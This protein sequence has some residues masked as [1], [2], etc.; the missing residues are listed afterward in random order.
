[1]KGCIWDTPATVVGSN[2]MIIFAQQEIL[3]DVQPVCKPM[4]CVFEVIS[5]NSFF[6]LSS[7]KISSCHM[8]QVWFS[9]VLKGSLCLLKCSWTIC[10]K[11]HGPTNDDSLM[12]WL[13][14]CRNGVILPGII[15]VQWVTFSS[16]WPHEI[17]P[18]VF[19]WCLASVTWMFILFMWQ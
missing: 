8:W 17:I 2:M 13:Y 5:K 9:C 15:I 16:L 4:P 6:P 14:Y 1:M 7:I 11:C 18:F 12:R 3:L 10:K 19:P